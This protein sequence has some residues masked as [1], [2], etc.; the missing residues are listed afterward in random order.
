MKMAI[1]I[2]GHTMGLGVIRGLAQCDIPVILLSYDQSDAGIGSRYVQKT[3]AVPHPTKHEKAFV[4]ALIAVVKIYPDAIVFPVSDASL[5]VVSRYKAEIESCGCVV[6]CTEWDVTR[7]FLEKIYT[8]ELAEAIGVPVPKT[9]LINTLDDAE[10]YRDSFLYPCIVKPHQSHLFYQMFGTKMFIVNNFDELVSCLRRALDAH[11]DVMVQEIIQGPDCNGANYNSYHYAG[12]A[13]VEFTAK[14]VRSGPPGFGSPRV[15]LTQ[16][17]PQIRIMGA[18]I[19]TAMNFYGFQCMEFKCDERDGIYKLV[20][21]N[22]RHNLSSMLAIQT[23]INFP[24]LHYNH[25]AYGILPQ[26]TDYCKDVYW[27]DLVRDI[28]YSLKYFRSEKQSFASFIEPYL[29]PHIFAI[30]SRQDP[31]PFVRRVAQVLKGNL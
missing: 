13:L 14:K 27:I 28:G 5:S 25:L 7:L 15:L 21:V 4:E 26:Q 3:V 23:G 6:A 18:K 16:D 22:G 17:I 20:E 29:K 19:L 1:V 12:E 11:L 31:K 9:R 2:S 10:T 8:Y 24:Y 30:L